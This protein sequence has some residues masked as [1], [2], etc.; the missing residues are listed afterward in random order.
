M[1]KQTRFFSLLAICLLM[2]FSASGNEVLLCET[3]YSEYQL[4]IDQKN[5]KI[6]FIREGSSESRSIAS[7]NKLRLSKKGAS[8]QAHF[9]NGQE[10]AEVFIQKAEK[11]S[12]ISD[13]LSFESPKGHKITYPLNCK[14]V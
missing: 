6:S 14:K 13:Y 5:K 3:S 10:K 12:E 1:I 11:P 2:A 7:T 9:Q 4:L 8:I